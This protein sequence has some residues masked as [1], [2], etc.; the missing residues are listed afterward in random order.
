MKTKAAVLYQ[1]EPPKPYAT[2]KPLVIEELELDPPGPGEVLVEVASAGLCHSDLS[3]INGSRPRVMP[4]V[5]GHEA[6]GVVQETGPGVTALKAGDHVVFSYVPICGHCGPCST[7]RASLCE[8]G[9]QANVA[10]ALLGGGRRF[11][12]VGGDALNHHL[13]VSGF[14]QFTV[15]AQESLI[16]IEKSF[17]LSKAALF[18]CAILTGVGSVVNTAKVEAGASVAVFGMGGVGLSAVMGA[19][20][21]GANPIIA[22]DLLDEKLA[23]AKTCGASHTVNAKQH[24]AESAVKDLTGGGAQYVFECSGHEA[25]GLQAFNATR[26]GGTTVFIGLPHP[27]KRIPIS[28]LT[29]VGEERTIKGSYMGS[30]VPSRD[31]PRFMALYQ[32]GLLP[33]DALVST[34]IGLDGVNAAFDVLDR[35]EAVRQ[36]ISFT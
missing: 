22:V 8:P 7:G 27:S 23:L 18:G 30:A 15:A 10:G 4:M 14:S 34:T 26:R 31:V 35:G 29:I 20:A 28:P 12:K 11:R 5:L 6:C 2:S 32:A 9:M 16:K 17:P 25:V 33:I 13:G 36:I 24:D 19:R 1:M 3:V 21:A